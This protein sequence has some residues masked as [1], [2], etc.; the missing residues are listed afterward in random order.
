MPTSQQS[1]SIWV[2]STAAA[3]GLL[4]SGVIAS[5]A[6]RFSQNI[7]EEYAKEIM[8]IKA[9]AASSCT[10]AIISLTNSRAY[11]KGLQLEL[12]EQKQFERYRAK[13]IPAD[14]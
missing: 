5:Q 12:Y 8:L 3:A 14:Q 13:V 7:H 4:M 2:A 1:I 10:E 11:L 6:Y 9:E